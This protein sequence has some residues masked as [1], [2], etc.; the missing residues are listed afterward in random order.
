MDKLSSFFDDYQVTVKKSESKIKTK[1]KSKSKC[2][3]KSKSKKKSVTKKIC[4]NNIDDN[5]I[6]DNNI[7]DNNSDDNIEN[8]NKAL[9][10][11]YLEPPIYD[12]TKPMYI[13]NRE[14]ERYIE[15]QTMDKKESMLE[16]FNIIFNKKNIALLDFKN[17]DIKDIPDIPDKINI[18]EI[19]DENPDI[20]LSLNIKWIDYDMKS[21]KILDNLLSRINYSF[22]KFKSL[23]LIKFSIKPYRYNKHKL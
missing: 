1:K 4:D 22:E 17:I 3:S 18:S 23:D 11:K 16:L 20:K 8:K 5:N 12:P 21:Y 14:M 6:D 7:D 15:Y 2:K 19:L 10:D 9:Y 13:F